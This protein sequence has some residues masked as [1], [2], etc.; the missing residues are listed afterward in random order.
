M[1]QAQNQLQIDWENWVEITLYDVSEITFQVL[2]GTVEIRRGDHTQPSA[3]ERGWQ[4][5]TSEGERGVALDSLSLGAGNR[6]WAKA[7]GRNQA[8]LLV[9]HA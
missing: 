7:L 1:P 2:A 3:E 8:L 6:V 9:D 5:S 4:Y